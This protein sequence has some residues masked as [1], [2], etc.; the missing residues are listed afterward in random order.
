[1]A[2]RAAT[3]LPFSRLQRDAA[4]PGILVR[5]NN[6]V[7]KVLISLRVICK[8]DAV[9]LAARWDVD[10]EPQPLTDGVHTLGYPIHFWPV[11]EASQ[12]RRLSGRHAAEK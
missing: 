10:F 8:N 4:S 3:A 7:D 2:G 12:N 9:I 5:D 11:A 1:M 6:I